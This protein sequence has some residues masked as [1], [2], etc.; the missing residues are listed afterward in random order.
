MRERHRWTQAEEQLLRANSKMSAIQLH[1][2]LF[3]NV[4]ALAIHAKR[5]KI[6]EHERFPLSGPW[7]E[8]ELNFLHK[9]F[10]LKPAKIQ[11]TILRPIKA[12]T[13]M[14]W[15][16]KK[17]KKS[18]TRG[19]ILCGA[20]AKDKLPVS[21]NSVLIYQNISELQADVAKIKNASI[22]KIAQV[23][24]KEINAHLVKLVK[25]LELSRM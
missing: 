19:S 17:G 7:S 9:N 10:N 8:D 1:E 22:R 5:H 25:V 12:I 16:M 13:N 24:L 6:F 4:S 20:I 14:R 11:K 3:K 23:E 21:E 15:A 2:T 18:V